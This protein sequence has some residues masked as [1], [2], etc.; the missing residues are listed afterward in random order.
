MAQLKPE[1]KDAI[2]AEYL[3]G[4]SMLALSKKYKVSWA[5]IKRAVTPL[6]KKVPEN[7]AVAAKVSL[8]EVVDKVAHAIDDFIQDTKPASKLITDSFNNL[9]LAVKIDDV[10]LHESK[11][12][13]AKLGIE[14]LSMRDQK[15]RNILGI[16]KVTGAE[17]DQSRTM[18]N[19]NDLVE[20]DRQ[21]NKKLS[22]VK[23]G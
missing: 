23:K 7:V 4:E 5:T 19:L 2:C 17:A 11:I 14:A 18:T 13:A 6:K 20:E 21:Q 16:D 3:N 8:D 12:K 15:I 9:E 1:T 22:I 10:R